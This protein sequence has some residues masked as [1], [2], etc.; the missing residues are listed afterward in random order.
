MSDYELKA[1]VIS[2]GMVS[3][4][5]RIR[6]A[7]FRGNSIPP[8]YPNSLD[9]E[10]AKYEADFLSKNQTEE[11]QESL[12]C[13]NND[14]HREERLQARIKHFL[15]SGE[16]IFLT[17]TFTDETLSKTSPE[18]RRRYV[19]RYLKSVSDKYVANIDYGAKNGREHYHAIVVG[20]KIDFSPWRQYGNINGRHVRVESDPKQLARYVSKLSNHAIKTTN[21][22]CVI[23]YSKNI[24]RDYDKNSR[25]IGGGFIEVDDT[26]S[27]IQDDREEIFK[28]WGII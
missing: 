20:D 5:K 10:T 13:V 17:L 15:Q 2:S 21:K 6:N 11:W 16:C 25:H 18:T 22:R 9:Y 3:E 27:S 1:Q 23:I 14:Y 26:W 7:L 4:V 28:N 8:K 12:R 24:F 19:T